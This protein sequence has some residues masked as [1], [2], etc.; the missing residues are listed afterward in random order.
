MSSNKSPS[1]LSLNTS[2]SIYP[3]NTP[4][5]MSMFSI[6]TF[7]DRLQRYLQETFNVKL[8]CER[9]NNNEKTRGPKNSINLKITGQKNDVE[10]AMEDLD[11][12]FSS[13]RTKKFDNTTGKKRSKFFEEKKFSLFI[14]RWK[15]DEN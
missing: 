12:L 2:T 4:D 1:T 7:E 8:I 6:E 15:L 3:I 10:N 11:N 5:R 13:L 9:S 14:F